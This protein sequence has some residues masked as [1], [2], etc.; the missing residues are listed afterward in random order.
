MSKTHVYIKWAS[1]PLFVGCG[2][3]IEMVDRFGRA[4]LFSYL[5]DAGV[6]Y[7]EIGR[8]GEKKMRVTSYTSD[9]NLRLTKKTSRSAPLHA[10]RCLL[11]HELAEK[12]DQMMRILNDYR[13]KRNPTTRPHATLSVPVLWS[14]SRAPSLTIVHKFYD[15]EYRKQHESAILK[16]L[17]EV[18]IMAQIKCI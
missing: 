2:E 11:G 8:N 12:S 16:K 17:Q 13:E 3:T 10:G 4:H 18:G 14:D 5:S 1:V 7:C 9:Y 15:P 6:H